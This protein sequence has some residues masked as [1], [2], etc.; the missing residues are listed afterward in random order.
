MK[1][2]LITESN[3]DVES[4]LI[5]ENESGEKKLYIEGIFATA[6]QK[7]KNGRIYPKGI[8][9]REVDKISQKM[10]ENR[11]IGELSHPENRSDVDLKEAAIRIV[12]LNWE[13]N[14]VLGK[15]LVLNTPSGNIIKALHEG[16][17]KYGISSRALGTVSE[18]RVNEDLDLK[19]W[20]VV[21]SPSN[22]GSWVNGILEGV[23][24]DEFDINELKQKIV[25]LEQE[26]LTYKEKLEEIKKEIS[27]KY[28]KELTEDLFNL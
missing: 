26:N 19:T 28:Y 6:E 24:F 14:N 21:D 1:K 17:C 4:N 12:S 22:I 10:R 20:D 16:G 2:Q 13:K 27:K 25:M 7:N 3:F 15:A 23:D 11:L 18:G 8:L 9:E 5:T